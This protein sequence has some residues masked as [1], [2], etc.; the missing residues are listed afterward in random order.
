ME[1]AHTN[2]YQEEILNLADLKGE[3][4]DFNLEQIRQNIAD[5]HKATIQAPEDL[6]FDYYR[7]IELVD[8]FTPGALKNI[9]IFTKVRLRVYGVS[10]SKIWFISSSEVPKEVTQTLFPRVFPSWTSTLFNSHNTSLQFF[11]NQENDTLILK[12]D[13]ESG[14][15]TETET[16][17][18]FTHLRE[19]FEIKSSPA[20][21]SPKNSRIASFLNFYKFDMDE[22]AQTTQ[23]ALKLN[24]K[25]KGWLDLTELTRARQR[26]ERERFEAQRLA[27]VPENLRP[28][29]R[30]EEAQSSF[31]F[32]SNYPGTVYVC[33]PNQAA[34]ATY[35]VSLT[36]KKIL[37]SRS[38]NVLDFLTVEKI[39]ELLEVD[40]E[41]D[42]DEISHLRLDK[43]IFDE[44]SDSLIFNF[45]F[46]TKEA[47]VKIRK[48]FES[49]TL[50]EDNIELK[51]FENDAE[52]PCFLGGFSEDRLLCYSTKI[53]KDRYLRPI[54]FLRIEDLV[55]EEIKGFEENKE[56]SAMNS[57]SS[58]D[59][60]PRVKLREGRI[61]IITD[62]F[63]FIYDYEEGEVVDRHRHTLSDFSQSPE[64]TQI[65]DVFGIN[66][67]NR[68][69]FIQ[70]E[71]TESG[72]REIKKIRTVFLKDLIPN[73]HEEM[74]SRSYKLFKLNNKNFLV[75]ASLSLHRE[76][77]GQL[78]IEVNEETF[79]ALK[80]TTKKNSEGQGSIIDTDDVYLLSD[81]LVFA[82]EPT[83]LPQEDEVGVEQ[84]CEYTHLTLAT[85]D[86]EIV[87]QCRL[88]KLSLSPPPIGMIN[89][90]RIISAGIANDIYLHE[91]QEESKKLALLRKIVLES[92][93]LANN[94]T[95]VVNPFA[96][97][98]FV[99]S[100]G[101]SLLLNFGQD[102]T[103]KSHLIQKG[104]QTEMNVFPVSK[105]KVILSHYNR[106]MGFK[107]LIYGL[108]FSTRELQYLDE[109][110]S[111][112]LG[113]SLQSNVNGDSFAIRRVEETILILK[114][115]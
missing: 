2:Q 59:R 68:F 22:D 73:L 47:I 30:F 10:E 77:H 103:L 72:D 65:G 88:T 97:C 99:E 106:E 26:R 74:V 15:L 28:L 27:Q 66:S 50:V 93:K 60:I 70:T 62:L 63:S 3:E 82:T 17:N 55:E 23:F 18:S 87:D 110:K 11:F 71:V 40:G 114:L 108:N 80:F 35:Q 79:E 21:P 64:V 9:I 105:D 39:K 46:H 61:L 34:V 102:L 16:S 32:Q 25:A 107:Y 56:F 101:R 37:R 94:L 86:W 57:F 51:I 58:Y 78:S 54:T 53:P 49:K 98:C 100:Q 19:Q 12:L 38:V 91:V 20:L 69:H 48:I 84:D 96:F 81:L 75:I 7:H 109:S 43:V 6:T 52:N 89:S 41:V 85:Q 33:L 14:K 115:N 92:G 8:G 76:N 42:V 4:I 24:N 111:I 90:N 113:P 5:V 29:F 13:S 67:L 83:Q 45:L 31:I 36:C 1:E 44:K 95:W 112:H 104:I